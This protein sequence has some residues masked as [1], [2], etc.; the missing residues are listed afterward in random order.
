M[1]KTYN[2]INWE[3]YPSN[4]TPLNEQ[5]LNKIDVALD[6]VDNRVITVDATKATKKEVAP[7]I[8]EISFNESNG[9]FTIT[10]KDGSKFTIDTK[11]EKIAIN[12]GYDILTQQISLTLIDGTIQYIDLSALITEYE[13]L[14]TDTVSFFVDENG[15]ASAVVKEGSIEEKHLRPD[16]LAEIKVEAAKSQTS[17]DNAAKSE[18]NAKKS[19][20]ASKTSETNAASS[21][22]S[23]SESKTIATQKAGAAEIFAMNAENSAARAS[24]SSEVATDKAN[25]SAVSETNA[26]NSARIATAEAN[27]ASVSAASAD[28]YSKKSQSYA[29]GGTGTR[30]N[31]DSDNAK[32]YY[33]QAKHISQGG[34]GL[35]PMGTIF[36]ANIPT[37]NIE[38]N[39]MYNIS[40]NFTSDERFLDGGSVFYGKGSNIYYT[41]DGKWDVLASSSVTGIKGDAESAYRQGNVNITPSDIGA[42]PTSGNAASATKAKQDGNGKNIAD[43]YLTK[44][45]DTYNNTTSF[46]ESTSR[47][48]INTGEKQSVI[49]GK[50]KKWFSDIKNG[51]FHTVANNLTTT[52]ANYVLD[53]RQGKILNDKFGGIT[54][55][56]DDDGN[57][58]YIKAGADTVTPF[59]KETKLPNISV[60]AQIAVKYT[61]SD[62]TASIGVNV[63]TGYTKMIL[64]G[65]SGIIQ[66]YYNGVAWSAVTGNGTYTIPAGTY[67]I[68]C[69]LKNPWTSGD[70]T[71][72][73][74]AG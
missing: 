4:K 43:T 38:P 30:E 3:N 66:M 10:R 71:I 50:I 15:K 54:F 11:I 37:S 70:Y 52:S 47:S 64:S 67:R 73:L 26:E 56:V 58:G 62:Y 1:N 31:E 23:A 45:G 34:N 22:T 61:E 42:L 68:S 20:T 12:F 19:E 40:D 17:A 25:A 16:Y 39:S 49:F 14:D 44:T 55:G 59:K 69:R 63:P 9:I 57:Y 27:V 7:L 36:F 33:E 60:S 18:A 32:Y 29:V 28:S 46:S 65:T 5:N 48:N 2:R 53:A 8:K 35:V 6:E 13:F 41:V 72:T 24:N 21:A 74:T 51:A